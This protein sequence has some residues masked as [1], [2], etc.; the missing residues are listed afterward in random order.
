MA[1]RRSSLYFFSGGS[2]IF[3][4]N[5]LNIHFPLFVA[6]LVNNV[7]GVALGAMADA[8]RPRTIEALM[9]AR[10]KAQA[11]ELPVG[12]PRGPWPT[13]V[14]AKV[15]L[16]AWARNP[17]KAGGVGGWGVSWGSRDRGNTVRGV[18]H[19]LACHLKKRHSCKWSLTLEEC[20]GG[21]AVWAG[22]G[23][24]HSHPLTQST[25]E[26]NAYSAMRS[27][28]DDLLPVAK[29]LAAAGLPV[30]DVLAWLKHAV[31][32]RG[33]DVTFNYEDV[34]AA[35]GASTADRSLD[36]TNLVEA[37]RQREQDQ[38]L[39]YRTTSDSD[40]CLDKVTHPTCFPHK[41][42]AAAAATVS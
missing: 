12:M 16:A 15:D 34:R 10:S 5:L 3:N 38:G 37:L 31:L 36:A 30:K 18:Q 32:A 14:D 7:A 26:S 29:S 35:T 39:F 9:L 20:Q 22:T 25:E 33:G 28:P 6:Q 11:A 21:W 8:A 4:L 13:D 24:E 41:A 1:A 19:V 27:I 40:G 23:C 42:Q 2:T 17:K